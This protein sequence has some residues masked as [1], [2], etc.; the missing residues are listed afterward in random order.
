MDALKMSGKQITLPEEKFT[1]GKPNRPQTP[2]ETIINNNFGENASHTL[3]SRYHHLKS[4]KKYN[5]PK[6]NN[7][8][9]RYTN[10]KKK[11]EEFIK[12]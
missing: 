12:T 8:E 2:I 4:F 3:Q 1:Y 11:A 10:A 9:I 5:T 7:I 6:C